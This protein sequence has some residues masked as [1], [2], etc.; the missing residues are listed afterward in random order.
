VFTLNGRQVKY[1]IMLAR[2]R[3]FSQVAEQLGISQPGLSKHIINLEQ[4]LGVKLF[5]RNTSPLT[6]TPAGE[7]FVREAQDLMQRENNLLRSMENF[8]SGDTGRLTIGVSPIRSLYQMPD[9]IRKLRERFP[10]LTVKLH[11]C[12]NDQLLKQAADGQY[13]F[14]ILNQPP[15]EAIFS[16]YP[17]KPESTVLMVPENLLGCIPA[18]AISPGK[19]YDM[20]DLS[21]CVDLPFVVLGEEQEMRLT[22]EKLCTIAGIPVNIA[23]EVI[24]V[25]TASAMAQAGVGA[26]LAPLQFVQKCSFS[27][28]VSL[29]ELKQNTFLRHPAVVLRRGQYISKYTRCAIDLLCGSGT[30][31]PD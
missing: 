29:F 4:D 21:R 11:E 24:N 17:L 19:C 3:N 23:A 10:G 7:H 12:I 25:S 13:D 9:V 31:T 1:A 28:S 26:A 20:V 5:N 30:F 2:V 16:I 8:K 15:D 6:L 22:Y 14:A 27:N 18:E